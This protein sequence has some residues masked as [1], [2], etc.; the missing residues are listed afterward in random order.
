MKL[1]RYLMACLTA[2]LLLVSAC[3]P[4]FAASV[5]DLTEETTPI[6]DDVLY[7]GV[8]LGASFG[9]RK[10]KLSNF[11]TE[12]GDLIKSSYEAESDTNAFTDTEKTK[13][14]NI[15]TAA[16]ADQTGAEIKSLYEAES[17]TNA[18]TDARASKLDAITGTNTGDEVAASTAEVTTGTD[19]TKM[20]TPAALEG[21]TPS[22]GGLAVTQTQTATSGTDNIAMDSDV[23]AAPGGASTAVNIAVRGKMSRGDDHPVSGAGHYVGVLGQVD[24]DNAVDDLGTMIAL[25]GKVEQTQA[26]HTETAVAV[27]A[28]LSSNAALAD[29]DALYLLDSTVTGN[30]GNIDVVALAAGQISGNNGTIGTVYTTLLTDLEEDAAGGATGDIA[31]IFGYIITDQSKNQANLYGMY[32]ANQTGTHAT[33]Y[34]TLNACPS[35]PMYT[36][37]DLQHAGSTSGVIAVKAPSVAGA[38][39]ITWPAATGT[40][41]LDSTLAVV[42]G[43]FTQAGNDAT[44]YSATGLGGTPIS[45]EIQMTNNTSNVES[46]FG[47]TDCANDYATI[48]NAGGVYQYDDLVVFNHASGGTDTLTGRIDTSNGSCDSDGFTIDFVVAGTPPAETLQFTWKALVVK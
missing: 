36:A 16:T 12:F 30:E 32:M 25:E 17:D 46:S 47:F 29:I 5:S 3:V 35:C 39:T 7:L 34:F 28:Q 22:L 21:A 40:P 33:K 27:E 1:H 6:G 9:D 10:L 42:T 4:A 8:D 18:L 43:K 45:I 31:N 13:L 48:N 26:G 14:G 37:G 41:L 11:F 19:N 38:N 20:V 15:E 44:N 24:N 23:E 2:A